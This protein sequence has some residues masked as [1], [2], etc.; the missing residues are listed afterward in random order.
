MLLRHK[1]GN[2]NETSSYQKM[3]ND[4]DPQIVICTKGEIFNIFYTK[5]ILV[6]LTIGGVFISAKVRMLF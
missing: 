4:S 6:Q 3:V 5:L 2:S 1:I